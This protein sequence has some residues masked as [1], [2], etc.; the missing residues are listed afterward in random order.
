MGKNKKN[1]SRKYKKPEYKGPYQQNPDVNFHNVKKSM[2]PEVEGPTVDAFS[3][4]D[5]TTNVLSNEENDVR[6]DSRKKRPTKERTT[7]FSKEN[8]VITLITLLL[9]AAGIIVYNYNEKFVSINKDI[10]YI[11]EDLSDQGENIE[12]V[13][14]KADGIDRKLDMLNLKLDLKEQNSKEK[15]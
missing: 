10:D 7:L 6:Q 11:K 12:K 1:K 14:D 15:K 5:S 2:R 3:E 8:L 9:G 13:E 4:S